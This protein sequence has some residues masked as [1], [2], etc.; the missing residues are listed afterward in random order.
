[1]FYIFVVLSSDAFA[2]F[3]RRFYCVSFTREENCIH[4]LCTQKPFGN[5]WAVCSGPDFIANLSDGFKIIVP[6][7]ST[8]DDIG[9]LFFV[10]SWKHLK[11]LYDYFNPLFVFLISQQMWHPCS[12]TISHFQMLFQNKVNR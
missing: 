2:L 4:N 9:K 6:C 11:Q 7:F 3:R 5:D 12:K 10:I 1:M 8:C